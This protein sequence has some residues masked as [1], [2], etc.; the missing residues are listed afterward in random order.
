MSARS[1]SLAEM[2][3]CR[4]TLDRE[5]PLS[6]EWRPGRSG[7]LVQKPPRTTR[8]PDAWPRVGRGQSPPM[9]LPTPP[10]PLPPVPYP[11]IGN[12]SGPRPPPSAVE[13]PL[14]TGMTVTVFPGGSSCLSAGTG[15][16]LVGWTTED[17]AGAVV[18]A[19]AAAAAT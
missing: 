6:V 19:G 3:R 9:P 14:L 8:D 15:A 1:S 18:V 10:M 13:G 4:V 11:G 2:A 16:V 7:S 12:S 17:G 5:L